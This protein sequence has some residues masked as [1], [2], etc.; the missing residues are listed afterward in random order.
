MTS[1]IEDSI[2]TILNDDHRLVLAQLEKIVAQ[3]REEDPRDFGDAWKTFELNLLSHLHTEEIHVFRAF[4]HAEP[5]EAEQLLKEHERIRSLLTELSIALDLHCLRA[6]QV[7]AL[8]D[9]VRA[10][11]AREDLLLYPWAARHLGRV[12]RDQVLQAL[13]AHR[14]AEPTG[15]L[16]TWRIDPRRSSL[17]FALRHAAIGEIAGRFTSWGGT[18]SVDTAQPTA[19]GATVWV[20]LASLETGD[21]ARDEQAR[22]PAFF[23]VERFPQARFGALRIRLPEGGNPIVDGRLNLHGV[24]RVV[25]LEIVDR[26]DATDGGERTI[27]KIRGRLDRREFGLRW[28]KEL[29]LR[30]ITVGAH[31]EIEAQVEAVLQQP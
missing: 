18:L 25:A 23:D 10:H 17:T 1:E 19:S 29:D 3:A 16:Q 28:N 2:Q 14:A 13:A 11:A 31:V 22:S 30:A 27:Y 9:E 26:R 7:A 12:V 15:V 4:R 24:E 5:R 20:D 6:D 21:A 8:A